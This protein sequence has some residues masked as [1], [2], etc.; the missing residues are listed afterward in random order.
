M[1]APATDVLNQDRGDRFSFALFVAIAAHLLLILGVTFRLPDPTTAPTS[2]SVTLV[3]HRSEAAPEHADFLAQNNQQASGTE[4]QRL[5]PTTTEVSHFSG[6]GNGEFAA[7]TNPGGS[8][9][10]SWQILSGYSAPEKIAVAQP[11]EDTGEPEIL[12]PPQLDAQSLLAQLDVL[13]Q[14]Y[15]R[16]PRI[17]TLTSVAAQ[18]SDEAAYQMLLQERIV[19]TGNRN[20]P[21]ES[22]QKRLFG[23]VRLKLQILPDG[24]LE[25]AEILESSGHLALDRAAVDIARM[26]GP[27]P[28]FP[29]NLRGKYDKLIFIRSWQF[30]PGGS[31][32]TN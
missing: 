27:F 9:R 31:L 23:S 20:Y 5:L 4:S 16:Q 8:P 12:V 7:P 1:N 6:E 32:T 17:G 14:E 29:E 24:T 22:L 25:T 30:L 2:L 21:A 11:E 18:A 26:A 28:A 3:T 19:A 10:E 13:R 15:A